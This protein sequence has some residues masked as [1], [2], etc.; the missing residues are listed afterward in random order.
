MIDA[1][2][3]SELVRGKLGEVF[4]KREGVFGEVGFE[5]LD[6]FFVE[7][8]RGENAEAGALHSQAETTA[9]AEKIETGKLVGGTPDLTPALSPRRGRI[10]ARHT[11][12]RGLFA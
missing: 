7:I 11:I 12:R 6:C 2:F 10:F 3:R 9:A 5:R 8:N 1:K 4:A